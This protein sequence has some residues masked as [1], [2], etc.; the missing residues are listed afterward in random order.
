[1]KQKKKPAKKN[2]LKESVYCALFKLTVLTPYYFIA[3]LYF[4]YNFFLAL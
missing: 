1:M 3:V 2:S 4:F